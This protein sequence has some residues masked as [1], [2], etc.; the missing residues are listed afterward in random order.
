VAAGALAQ[1]VAELHRVVPAHPLDRALVTVGQIAELGGIGVE[2]TAPA[3]SLPLLPPRHL[4]P[5]GL[6]DRRLPDQKL[7][8]M[9]AMLGTFAILALWFIGG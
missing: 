8:N 6:G 2:L 7:G 4:P 9:P 1:A 3:L 5:L